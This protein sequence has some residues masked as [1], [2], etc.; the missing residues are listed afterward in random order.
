[1]GEERFYL[2][3]AHILRVAFVVEED[4]AL[5]PV[6]VGLLGADG[7]VLA[8]DGVSNLIEQLLSHFSSP[9]GIAF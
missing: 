8:A 3:G 4:E 9:I 2:W 6:D 5:D 7:V 1:M